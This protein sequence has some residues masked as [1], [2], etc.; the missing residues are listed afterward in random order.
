MSHLLQHQLFVKGEKCEFHQDTITFLGYVISQIGV[1]ID[2][3]KVKAVTEW[4]EPTTVKELQCF[5]GFDNFYRRFIRNYSG[6][7]SPL[8]SLLRGWPKQLKWNKEARE[9]FVRLKNSFTTTPILR[10]PDPERP[11]IVEV[12]ASNF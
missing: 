6:I 1:G 12:D 9:A 2:E 4:P 5:L 11:F 7:A 3:S 8:T 10:H